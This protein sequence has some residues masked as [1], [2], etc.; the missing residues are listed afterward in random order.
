MRHICSSHRSPRAAESARSPETCRLTAL[1]PR[2]GTKPATGRG[3]ER[4]RSGS[5]RCTHARLELPQSDTSSVLTKLPTPSHAQSVFSAHSSLDPLKDWPRQLSAAHELRTASGHPGGHFER[6]H[7]RSY[8]PPT[9][10]RYGLR[11]A[12]AAKQ[13]TLHA[14]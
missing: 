6:R 13:S 4:L 2:A 11:R 5:H 12:G 3:S 9:A 1:R 10:T 8:E 7:R 14:R